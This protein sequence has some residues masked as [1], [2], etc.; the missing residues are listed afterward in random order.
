MVLGDPV[1]G[2][3]DEVAAYLGAAFAIEVHSLTPR[4]LMTVSEIRAVLTKVVSL[5][6]QMVVDH[7]QHHSQSFV[8]GG[9]DQSLQ[10]LR[11]TVRRVWSVEMGT[12]ITPVSLSWNLHHWHEFHSGDAEIVFQIVEI[13]EDGSECSVRRK[14]PRMEFIEN[15]IL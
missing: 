10:A 8:V 7:I 9:V 15:Q 3:V 4:S 13:S 11:A 1:Q 6:P 2:I 12:V 5:R 14:G